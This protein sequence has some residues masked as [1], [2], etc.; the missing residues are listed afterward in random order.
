[1]LFMVA[2]FEFRIEWRAS[3]PTI[4]AKEKRQLPSI[5]ARRLTRSSGEQK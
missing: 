2:L 1:L 3:H 5:E 4:G